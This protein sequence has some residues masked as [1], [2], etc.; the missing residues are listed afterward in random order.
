MDN[1]YYIQGKGENKMFSYKILNETSIE[2]LHQAF[3][4]AFSDYQVKIDLP[5]W[6]F[7]GMLQRRGY[8][9]EISMGAFVDERLVGFVLN[10]LRMWNGKLTI[11]DV[12]TGVIGE[13]RRQGVTNNILSNIKNIIKEKAI[14]QYLLEVLK[15]NESAVQLY[16]NQGFQIEREL[17]CFQLDKTQYN[18]VINHKVDHVNNL[19]LNNLKHFWN[20][21]PSWQNS[22]DSINAASEEFMYSVVRVDSTIVGYGIIDKKSRDI[23]QIAVDKN[24]RGKGIG[25]SIITDFINN[26]EGS[27]ISILNVD[28]KDQSLQNF[29]L[30]LGFKNIVTQ[31]EMVLK[32]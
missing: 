12:G 27:K 8:V 20:F 24:F 17:E 7:E 9:A 21:S 16:K 13:Y 23:P 1:N 30:K 6:K 31:Y 19:D 15:P 5:I 18:P 11:Y 29:L 26:T 10:G 25:R 3:V 4:D 22:I 28:A 32:I 14:E 2:I